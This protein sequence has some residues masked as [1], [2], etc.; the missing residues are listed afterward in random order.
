MVLERVAPELE[1]DIKAALAEADRHRGSVPY[2]VLS[3]LRAA[4]EDLDAI[5]VGRLPITPP[6]RRRGGV[7]VR[8]RRASPT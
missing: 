1:Q 2:D 6:R 8:D 5:R 4:Q 3:S 7:R